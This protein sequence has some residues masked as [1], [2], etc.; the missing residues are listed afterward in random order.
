MK[1]PKQVQIIEPLIQLLEQHAGNNNFTLKQLKDNQTQIQLSSMDHYR[2]IIN[3]LKIK[4]ANF[5]SNLKLKEVT[6]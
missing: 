2:K 1:T 3:A 6:R 5:H 4:N